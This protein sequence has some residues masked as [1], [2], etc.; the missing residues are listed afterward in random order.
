MSEP[1]TR[2][3]RRARS[4]DRASAAAVRRSGG[5]W[6]AVVGVIGELM[7]TAGVLVLLFIGWKLWVNDGVVDAAQEQAAS[8]YSDQWAQAPDTSGDTETTTT[9]PDPTIDPQGNEVFGVV[10]AER[11]GATWQRPI[12]RGVERKPVL[13]SIG[14]GWYPSTQLPG[15][16]GNF[17]IAAHRGGQGSSFRYID[18]LQV[19]DKITIETPDGWYVYTF[20][21]T[22]YV[23]ETAVSVLDAVPQRDGVTATARLLTL[24][25]CNPYPLSH[26]ERII[27]YAVFDSFT[28]RATGAPAVLDYLQEG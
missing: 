28:P 27:A 17:A 3:E 13:D 1:Q 24:T 22:E 9:P 6:R 12:A 20:R 26:G 19:G 25:S 11:L 21:N 18:T 16:V 15:Q 14:A 10:Y 8:E 7:L 23:M 5:G 2:R 4:G